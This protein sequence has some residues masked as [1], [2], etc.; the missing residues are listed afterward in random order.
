[1]SRLNDYE[2]ET[3]ELQEKK[4]KLFI[5]TVINILN[6]HFQ[7]WENSPIL[8][9]ALFGEAATVKIVSQLIL[10]ELYIQNE[11]FKIKEHE[12]KMCL[13]TFYTF[14]VSHH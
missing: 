5:E 1:M 7:K 14:K 6:K 12:Q 4:L 2:D 11:V 8:V 9:Y 13:M 10:G 3:E